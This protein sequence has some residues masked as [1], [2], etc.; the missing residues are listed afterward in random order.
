MNDHIRKSPVRKCIF[1]IL[2]FLVVFLIAVAISI[3]IT[4]Y[5]PLMNLFCGH[6]I[7]IA[8]SNAF[9]VNLFL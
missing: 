7:V 3:G 8:R 9:G 5:N 2:Y 6:S 1:F 4:L